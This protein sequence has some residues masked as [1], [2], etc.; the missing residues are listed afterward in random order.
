[1]REIKDSEGRPW[2]LAITVASAG[3]VRD[4]VRITPPS[5]DGDPP[6]PERPFDLA[7]AATITE[8][9]Q[10]LRSNFLA[11]G[12]TLHA[13][14]LPQVHEKGLTREQFL[15]GL[16]GDEL[17]TAATAIEEELIGFF[18]Q[19]LRGM[20]AALARKMAE[21][22][23]TLTQQAEEKV[24]SLDLAALSSGTSSGNAPESLESIPANGPSENSSPPETP[25]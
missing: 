21:L 15:E 1:M 9:F 13:L 6:Q 24:Q 19:R 5:A 10:I 12:E 2:R 25:A 4:M 17:D 7:D 23:A 22:A 8:T 16:R 20:V 3:R 14:L 11:V 18:P